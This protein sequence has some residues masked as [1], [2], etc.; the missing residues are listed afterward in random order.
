MSLEFYRWMK[1]KGINA[2]RISHQKD[3]RQE[4]AKLIRKKDT[5]GTKVRKASGEP[6]GERMLSLYRR[7]LQTCPTAR[8]RLPMSHRCPR[9]PSQTE[10]AATEPPG[11][12]ENKRVDVG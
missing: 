8:R 9:T 5:A 1:S 10:T 4:T 11:R 3:L 7:H 2:T 6:K 12:T